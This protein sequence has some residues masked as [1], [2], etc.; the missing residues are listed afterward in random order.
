VPSVVINGHYVGVDK[1]GHFFDQGYAYYEEIYLRHKD[2]M[3]TIEN[4]GLEDEDGGNGM[5][6]NGI[7]SYGDMAANFRGYLFWRD[8]AAGLNP[9]FSCQGGKYVRT[10]RRF[11]WAEYVTDA[12]DEALNCSEFSPAVQKVVDKA[13][14]GKPHCPVNPKACQTILDETCGFTY[15]SPLCMPYVRVT[16]IPDAACARVIERDRDSQACMDYEPGFWRGPVTGF[17]AD[18]WDAAGTM[19]GNQGRHLQRNVKKLMELIGKLPNE[20]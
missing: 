6:S 4:Y 19:I 9:Y 8:V 14:A 10:A 1:L 15:L 20:I 2:P 12:W 18:N 7:R 11:D 16:A 17:I 13:L 3:T 5:A